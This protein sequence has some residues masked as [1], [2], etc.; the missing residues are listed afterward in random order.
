MAFRRLVDK[1]VCAAQYWRLWEKEDFR[2]TPF[3]FN[4]G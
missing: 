2:T 3:D 4:G 1:N